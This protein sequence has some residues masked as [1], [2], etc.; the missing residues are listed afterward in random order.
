MPTKDSD[1]P[2]P[3]RGYAGQSAEALSAQ[4][5]ER[6]LA[7]GLSLFGSQGYAA[8]SISALCREARVTTRHFY[9]A[10]AD[11]EALLGAVFDQV[12]Q[13]AAEA[14]LASLAQPGLSLTEQVAAGVRAFVGIQLNDPRRARISCIEVMGVSPALEVR[15]RTVMLR[16]AALLE[17]QAQQL[18]AQGQ[19]P[20]RSYRAWA[21]AFVGGV[22]E[23]EI[24]WLLSEPRPAP[25]TVAEEL[26]QL[27]QLLLGGGAGPQ[28]GG[29]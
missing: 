27:L 6:L 22:H 13:E 20:E 23:L 24:D 15:R 4:R 26:V 5:R 25:E 9:E 14:V 17:A 19:I 21:L 11:R 29:A 18:V 8:T 2:A 10:F 12:M 28:L 7:A 1:A 16:F 3:R